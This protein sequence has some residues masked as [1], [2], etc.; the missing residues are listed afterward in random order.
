M[1]NKTKKKGKQRNISTIPKHIAPVITLLG[2]KYDK[3]KLDPYTKIKDGSVFSVPR[4]DFS[5]F[6]ILERNRDTSKA[7]VNKLIGSLQ[8]PR[9]QVEPITINEKWE[10]VNGQHRLE[11]AE[12]GGLDHVIV[13]MSYGATIKDVIVMNTTQKRWIFWDF[14]KCHSHESASNSAEYQKL[15]KFLKDYPISHKAA[16]WLLTGNNH[17]Y[18]MEDFEAGTLKVLHLEEAQKQGDLLRKVKGFNTVDVSIWKFCYA[19]VKI[20]NARTASGTKMSMATLMKNLKKYGGKFFNT[21]G[22]QEYYLDEMKECYNTRLPK[23][24]KI[25][26]RV[27]L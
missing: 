12:D 17:D 16:L 27:S 11:A 15:K 5:K 18:G 10:V 19:F 14:L 23:S 1:R 7:H 24:K 2:H 9:G 8:E 21:G 26:L 22:N 3:N 20:Q 25:T 13:I 4:K 6:K